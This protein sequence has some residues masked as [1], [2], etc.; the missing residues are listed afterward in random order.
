MMIVGAA[1]GAVSGLIVSSWQGFK[2][3]PWEGFSVP[4]FFR[5]ILVGAAAGAFFSYLSGE[6][7]LRI[8]NRGI[9]AFAIVAVER[10]IGEAYKGFFRRGAHEEYFKLLPKLRIPGE[11]YIAKL[12]AGVGFLIAAGWLFRLLAW[13]LERLSGRWDGLWAPGLLV[14]MAAGL[15][16]VTGWVWSMA[17]YRIPWISQTASWG[18]ST[19][20]PKRRIRPQAPTAMKRPN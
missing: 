6:G 16:A 18:T 10:V 5:S 7:I 8:D 19:R 3:P 9:L 14:G 2:D 13:W 12:L 4:K 17:S 15:L 20:T 11:I 1:I